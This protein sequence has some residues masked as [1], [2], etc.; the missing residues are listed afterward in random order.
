M[1]FS[2]LL[3]GIALRKTAGNMAA[4][5]GPPVLDSRQVTSGS[6]F[7]A[8]RGST[9]NGH[10]YID[11]AIALGANAIV[12]EELPAQLNPSI[13]YAEVENAAQALGLAASTYYGHPSRK[14]TLVGVTGTNG[15][16]TVATLLYQLFSGLGYTTG[17]FSTV[18]NFIGQKELPSTHTTPDSASL[19]QILAQMLAAGC[20]HVFMEVSSHAQSQF[21]TA[22]LQFA[23]GLFTNLTHDHLDYHGTFAA[24]R[25]AK[26]SFFD[27]LPQTAFALT[28]ADDKNGN[29]MVQ[30]TI[31][32]RLAYSLTGIAS[33]HGRLLDCGITG[34]EMEIDGHA[35]F[36]P[37]PGRFNA[38]NALAVYG[39]AKELGEAPENIL[40]IL[41]TLR[42]AP[43]RF[44]TYQ[45][46]SG[47]TAIVDYAHTPDALKNV[48]ETIQ[49]LRQNG[50][51]ATLGR[52][53]TLVG[54]GGDRDTTKRP[55]MAAIASRLSD[56]LILT[57]DNPRSEDPAT[58]IDQMAT[59][60]PVSNRARLLRE[61]DRAKAIALAFS[62]ALPGDI[63]LIAGKGHETYQ[64]IQGIKHP[65]DD[66]ALVAAHI[67][68]LNAANLR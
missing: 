7:F 36:L 18:R 64:E 45:S 61:P 39:A 24:Y 35:V 44:E 43:G 26:Q 67:R 31:A 21:R 1:Q 53:L 63:I 56:R 47:I 51:S 16:T 65:F 48:L 3:Y 55:E 25:Q 34:N 6:A 33:L 58:I 11:T 60:V 66:R 23:G 2:E 57:S 17:L 22:G 20:T 42:G 10:S 28:N 68:S 50:Q 15:K 14:L 38:Y 62:T 41:S 5:V 27:M 32:R 46:T 12:C 13:A 19:N 9:S 54:A 4:I 29:I 30:N 40:T 37:M 8:I 52:V 59:G 49:E